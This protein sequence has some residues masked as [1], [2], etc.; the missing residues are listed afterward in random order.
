MKS[1]GTG[2]TG[3]FA[4]C[5]APFRINSKNWVARNVV[6]GSP[7]LATTPSQASLAL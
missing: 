7:E 3:S 5:L 6:Q 4:S 2:I 1:A